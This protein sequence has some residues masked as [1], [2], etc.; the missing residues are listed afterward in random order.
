MTAERGCA[1]GVMAKAPVPGHAK[2]RLMPLLTAEQ[3]AAI[4]AA[5]LRDVTENIQCAAR[6]IPIHGCIAYAPAGAAALFAPHI[7]TGTGLV[8]ADG[9]PCLPTRVQGFGR[10]L[11]H[12]VQTMLAAGYRAACVLNSDSP[13]LPTVLLVTAVTALLERP[14]RVVLGPAEDGGY[15]LLG[16]TKPHAHLF[17]DISWSTET[18]AE[19]TRVRTREL[20]LELIELAP[21]YDVDDPVSLLRLIDE[22]AEPPVRNGLRP[23]GAPATAACLARV[24]LHRPAI[25]LGTP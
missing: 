14:G 20:G 16:V 23:Y 11:L 7:A 19:S 8:L 17:E 5:F 18:V 2:T 1:I 13:N 10:C 3:A 12:A 25:A 22:I 15:Y 4:S 6:A 21:W 9:S 24:G